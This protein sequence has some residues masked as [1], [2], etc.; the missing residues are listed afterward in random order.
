MERDY[1]G[2]PSQHVR[3]PRTADSHPG[4]SVASPQTPVRP[5]DRSNGMRPYVELMS[6]RLSQRRAT[7][8]SGFHH[9]SVQYTQLADGMG[10]SP[11]SSFSIHR[12]E[13]SPAAD[14]YHVVSVSMEQ[15]HEAVA[16]VVVAGGTSPSVWVP[17]NE[18]H[19][20]HA[21]N[22][23]TVD[24]R[25]VQASAV[26]GSPTSQQFVPTNA[27]S[28]NQLS[29]IHHSS[30]HRELGA[31]NTSSLPRMGRR[32]EV[33]IAQHAA[34]RHENRSTRYTIMRAR[35]SSN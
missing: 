6:P 14:Y 25:R 5:V 15:S 26:H 20:A 7:N 29:F 21:H 27:V 30:P 2:A 31:Y 19:R 24:P 17:R 28:P 1:G 23:Q 16:P 32:H 3:S 33:N 34:P 12:T 11:R 8:A 10:A 9:H 13:R 4:V 35:M 22:H 18:N